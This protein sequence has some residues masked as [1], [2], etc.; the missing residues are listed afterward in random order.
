MIVVDTNVLIYFVLPG[1][2]TRHVD[3]LVEKDPEWAAPTLWRRE[4]M[5][6]LF[7]LIR[8]RGTS[9]KNAATAWDAACK[10][11]SGHEYDITSSELLTYATSTGLTAYDA[12]FAFLA[13]ALG[14]SLVTYDKQVL[15]DCPRIAVT[16]E[17][18]CAPTRPARPG[19]GRQPPPREK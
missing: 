7:G 15:R 1:A 16:P 10:R 18:F 13:E 4:F 3:M 8:A 19:G 5:N 2:H 11:M 17:T 14:V 12:E 9:P 6:A